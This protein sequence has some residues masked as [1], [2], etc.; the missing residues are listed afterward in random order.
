MM[1]LGVS[2]VVAVGSNITHKF[3][4]TLIGSRKHAKLGNVDKKLAMYLLVTALIAVRLAVWIN[5]KLFPSG[6]DTTA[7]GK[8][9]SPT[10][11]SASSSSA[12]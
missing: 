3:G 9:P 4:K 7:Q 1:N 11:T 12:S 5:G 2:G 6:G 8:A 10:S